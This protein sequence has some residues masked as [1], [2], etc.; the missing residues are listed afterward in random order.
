MI[1]TPQEDQE[2]KRLVGIYG[3]HAWY[4]ICKFMPNKTEIRCF[5]RWRH[6]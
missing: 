1:W 6:L 3:D 4:R 5:N 2:L